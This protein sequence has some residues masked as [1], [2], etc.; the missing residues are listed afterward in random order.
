MRTVLLAI[1][2]LGL[3]ACGG[4]PAK[5]AEPA[6]EAAAASTTPV[7]N[8]T[9][10][11][12][13]AADDANVLETADGAMFHTDTTKTEK[14]H[15]PAGNWTATPVDAA[16][17]Q[18]IGATDMAMPDGA[19]H[20]VVEVKPLTKDVIAKVKFERRDTADAAAPVTETRTVNF[21]VH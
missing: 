20:H 1:A 14:V 17:I 5:P 4:E 12:A 15:L 13:D 18:V 21:M 6:P 19:T 9:M 2:A 7:M 16:Q 10:K 3:S 11:A 8:D